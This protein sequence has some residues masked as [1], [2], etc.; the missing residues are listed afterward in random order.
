APAGPLR[1][2]GRRFAEVA[3]RRP[4]TD[5]QK[6]F[7][8][9]HQFERAPD[10]DTAVKRVVLLVLTSPRFLYR[11]L[12]GGGDGYDVASR[13]SFG[14]W[15]SLPDQELLQA[16]A[17]GRLGTRE[18][19]ARQ[20][21][22]MP[23]DLRARAKGRAVLPQYPEGDQAPDLAKAPKRYPGFDQAV[24]SDLRTSLDLF[25]ED[26]V[27]SP[28]SDYRQ[29][30]LSDSLYLNGRLAKFYGADLPADA[31][32]QKIDLEPRAR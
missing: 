28:S 32:F 4:L 14:L 26:V 31:P 1:G 24:I 23:G 22:R 17:G 20:A 9:D 12:N 18:Q 6:R 30:L 15:D 13:L 7:F 29:L 16:A 10:P 21:E 8:V 5:E 25:L 19:G 3:F 11:E 2:F 27:W